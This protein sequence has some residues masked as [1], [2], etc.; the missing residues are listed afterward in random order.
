MN[1]F[2]GIRLATILVSLIASAAVWLP[3]LGSVDASGYL[4]VHF[5]DVGQGDAVF[6]Q[7]PD[8]IE[9]LIDGGANSGVLSELSKH[10]SFFDRDIDMI[11]GTHPDKDHIGGLVDVLERYNVSSVLTTENESDSAAYNAYATAVQAEGATVTYARRGQVFTLGAS[12]TLEV[13]FPETDTTDMESNAASIVLQLRYGETEV[14]L[15][16]DS[17]KRIEEYLVLTQGEHLQSD[18]LKVGHHGSRTSTAQMFLEEVDPQFAV[19][20]AEKNS[21][22]GHPHVEVTDMLFNQRVKTY[23]TAQEGTV[24]FL[25]DGRAAWVAQ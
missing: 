8:G 19:I 16:G 18:V 21:R 9:I 20:S 24:S 3:S 6:I 22:Y 2:L 17:P 4:Q 14:L 7:T 25:C 23:S 11:V 10:M 5:L 1:T 13:L 15:T 12:T